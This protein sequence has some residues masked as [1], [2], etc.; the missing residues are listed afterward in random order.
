MSSLKGRG[1]KHKNESAEEEKEQLPVEQASGES[2]S[3]AAPVSLEFAEEK[4]ELS[5]EEDLAGKLA[6]LN[7]QWLR[8]RAEYANFK[9]RTEEDKIR[10][11][12]EV[13]KSVLGDIIPVLD[14]FRRFFE[15]LA[16]AE[17]ITDERFV[18]G[19]E[20]IRN[21]VL[22]TLKK[23][24]VEIIDKAGVTFDPKLHEAVLPVP[25]KDKGD[26]QKVKQVLEVGYCLGEIVFRPA[27][28]AVG[29]FKED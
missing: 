1:K 23:H 9:R 21:T 4:K 7:D 6:Q 17:K 27:K 10:L 29:V 13:K 18:Q 25:V 20:I 24:G 26:D 8:L 16:Q 19:I 28:V 22:S 2:E 12:Y 14:D 3:Q 15:Y 5:A 11:S